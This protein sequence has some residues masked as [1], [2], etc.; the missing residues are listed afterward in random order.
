METSD[1]CLYEGH[2]YSCRLSALVEFLTTLTFG[3][4]RR[5]HIVSTLLQKN[6]KKL[7]FY[8]FENEIRYQE[9]CNHDRPDCMSPR[10]HSSVSL[11]SCLLT[12]SSSISVHQP[13][14][15]LF[16]SV[17][18]ACF[19]ICACNTTSPGALNTLSTCTLLLS[20]LFT[21]ISPLS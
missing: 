2:G 13:A 1:G 17:L 5:H 18:F 4:L 20:L 19:F 6:R 8:E 15:V 9:N 14:I 16:F 11:Y 7:G 12:S 3:A 21:V 10:P